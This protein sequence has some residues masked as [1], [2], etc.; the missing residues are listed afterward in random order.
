MHKYLIIFLVSCSIFFTTHAQEKE[1]VYADSSLLRED[2]GIEEEEYEVSEEIPDTTLI[3]RDVLISL[4]TINYLRRKKEFAYLSTIDSLLK[5]EQKKSKNNTGYRVS[6]VSFLERLFNSPFIKTFFW[7]IAGVVF[8][9]ILYKLLITKGSFKR[10]LR[11]KDV[12]EKDDEVNGFISKD[13]MKMVQQ[14]CL[15]GDYRSAVKFQFLFTLQKLAERSL[16]EYA[17]DKTN[18]QYLQEVPA[19]KK[20]ELARLVLNYEYI[21]YGNLRVE[22][23]VYQK[24]ENEF[25]VFQNKM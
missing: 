18:Y 12:E 10:N 16:I 8:L 15:L 13:Y 2:A 1:F 9:F 5:D 20:K 19:D 23:E 7:I 21:W 22:R 14:S 6:Q 17:T 24:V 11:K 3:K 4:D 25:I